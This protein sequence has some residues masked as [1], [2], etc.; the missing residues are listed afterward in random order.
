L[1]K[2]VLVGAGNIGSRHLQGLA[3][4]DLPARITVVDPN[5]AALEEARQKYAEKQISETLQTVNY[6]SS[7]SEIGEPI[8]LVIIATNSDRRYSIAEMLL[9]QTKVKNI[10]FEKVVFQSAAEFTRMGM[11]LAKQKTK[12]WVNC[13]R[14]FSGFYLQLKQYLGSKPKINFYLQ[15]GEWGLGCNSIHFLDL[16]AFLADRSKIE[17]MEFSGNIIVSKRPGFIELAGLLSGRFAGG[18]EFFLSAVR[19]SNMPHQIICAARDCFAVIDES[20]GKAVL[21]SKLDHWQRKE[22]VFRL[23]FQSELTGKIARQIL[24]EGKSDLSTF[25][26]SADLHIPLLRAFL[27]TLNQS[28][29]RKLNRCPIT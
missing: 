24:T 13:P 12:A 29:K 9:K 22:Q 20:A 17:R 3:T 21:A 19:G 14:R 28:T 23:P 16:I 4:L 11:L 10:I 2:M 15:G 1:Y 8:D 6:L 27:K 5:L 25:A 7:F 26:E 18:S